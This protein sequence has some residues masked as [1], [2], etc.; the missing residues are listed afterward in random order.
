M[1]NKE[2]KITVINL[3]WQCKSCDVG[4][5]D[6]DFTFQIDFHDDE[7]TYMR[8]CKYHYRLLKDL[9]NAKVLKPKEDE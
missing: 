2:N 1:N 6:Y 7:D 8:V 3:A 9:N 5:C 4:L